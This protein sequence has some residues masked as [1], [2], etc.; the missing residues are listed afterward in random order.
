MRAVLPLLWLLPGLACAGKK[1]PEFSWDIEEDYPAKRHYRATLSEGTWMNVD[2]HPDGDRVVFDLLGDLYVVPLEGGEAERLTSGLAWDQDPRFS[3]D[4]TKLVYISDRDG[5][6]EVWIRE[7]ASG[8]AEVLTEGRPHRFGEAEWSPDGE[9]LLLR[10][11]V[12]D[13]RSI[14]MCELWLFDIEGG[15]GIQLTKTKD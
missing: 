8:E 14:G 7:M 4:G 2:V 1:E 11:R 12:V 5:N 3:P 9:H 13:T 15:D 10:K 6:Q